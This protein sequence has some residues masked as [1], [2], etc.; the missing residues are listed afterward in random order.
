M[1]TAARKHL[2]KAGGFIGSH[3]LLAAGFF[4]NQG[5]FN[6]YSFE[7]RALVSFKVIIIKAYEKVLVDESVR[8]AAGV[9]LSRPAL[10]EVRDSVLVFAQI[11]AGLRTDLLHLAVCIHVTRVLISVVLRL[12]LLENLLRLAC[13]QF[14]RFGKI[15]FHYGI[16]TIV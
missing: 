15:L 9:T 12:P 14:S 3:S 5:R 8:W 4:F 1:E 13:I 2:E 11:Q 16:L 7:K 10:V 6:R